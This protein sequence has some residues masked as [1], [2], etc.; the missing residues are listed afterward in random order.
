MKKIIK[1]TILSIASFS[2]FTACVDLE[3]KPSSLLSPETF[4]S[5]E[6]D[7][8]SAV[9]GVYQP[10]FGAYSGFDFGDPLCGGAGAEDIG[11]SAPRWQQYDNFTETTSNDVNNKL[12]A[13]FYKSITN[14]NSIIGNARKASGIAQAKINEFEGQARFLRAFNYFHLTQYFGEVPLITF[15]NQGKADKVGQSPVAAIYALII[16]DLKFAEESLP[17]SFPDKGRA[18]KGAAKTLLAEVYLT[19]ACWPIEDQSMYALAKA[20][21]KEVMDMGVYSL[22]PDFADL[23]KVSKKF[24]NKESIFAFYGISSG[25]WMPA[26]HLHIATRPSVEWGWGD[27]HSEARFYNAFPNGYRKN[28]SF[29]TQFTDG[30][31]WLDNNPK[32]P[33]IGKYRD[34]GDGV[35]ND[36][37][38]AVMMYR[39]AEVLLTYAEAA[40]MSENGPSADALKAINMVRRRANHLDPNVPN[41]GVDLPS[42]MS[43][44]NFDKAVIAERAWELAFENKRWFDLVRKKMV[45]EV[46]VALYPNVSEKNK[47]LPK[48]ALQVQLTEGLKQNEGY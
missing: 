3:E 29:H 16:E 1:I 21:A 9:I 43:K 34:G 35:G 39:Y 15:E 47:W 8:E 25:G 14:A 7:F 24:T 31:T 11:A 48:P 32:Q 27:F 44:T 17:V 42:G 33:F 12:W 46:N 20:K 6:K 13:M 2:M 45:V 38:A 5:S 28:I 18:T 23:W 4:F 22:E 26:S 37:E 19:M 36:G 10:L 30:S 40:N 41:V